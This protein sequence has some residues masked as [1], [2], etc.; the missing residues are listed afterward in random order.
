MVCVLSLVCA[1]KRPGGS[2][3]ACEWWRLKAWILGIDW[4]GC[5][6]RVSVLRDRVKRRASLGG[7]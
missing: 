6:G 7:E 3:R 5:C 4:R 2:E 1:W